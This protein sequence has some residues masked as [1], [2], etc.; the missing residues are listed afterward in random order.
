[1]KKL[2]RR[3]KKQRRGLL[4]RYD[5]EDL[6][7]LRITLRRMRGRLEGTGDEQLCQLRKDLGA[8]ADT[9]NPA[10]DWDTLA[11]CARA[12]LKKK[13]FES[14]APWL[15]QHQQSNTSLINCSVLVRLPLC[16]SAI[17]YGELT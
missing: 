6:H 2:T 4:E 5:E 15:R 3:L 14:L 7:Q 12:R 16:A 13:Q 10:R 17:P 1:M 9:T 11:L 8:L